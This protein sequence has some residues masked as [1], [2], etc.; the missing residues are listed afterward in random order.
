MPKPSIDREENNLLS[1]MKI[2]FLSYFL[3][4]ILFMGCEKEISDSQKDYFIKMYGSYLRDRAVCILPSTSG[5]FLVCGTS[6]T[7]NNGSDI[8]LFTIDESGNRISDFNYV[9]LEGNDRAYSMKRTGNGFVIS[10]FVTNAQGNLDAAIF[11]VNNNGEIINDL[12][13]FG[14][15]GNDYAYDVE[16]RHEEG[17]IFVGSTQQAGLDLLYIVTVDDNVEGP[18]VSRNLSGIQARLNRVLKTSDGEYIA[19]GTNITD[20]ANSYSRMMLTRINKD[21][22]FY[23]VRYFGNE[24]ENLILNDMVQQNDS[25]IFLMGTLK[26]TQTEVGRVILKKIVDFRERESYTFSADGSLDAKALSLKEDGSLIMVADQTIADDKNVMLFLLNSEGQEIADRKRYGGTGDQT[27]SDV[28][29]QNGSIL[30]LGANSY[31]GNSMISL[32]KTDENGNT[33]N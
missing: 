19:G 29:Y 25:V 4:I 8:V 27:A 11:T 10:A 30:I 16:E 9:G 17:Y 33:W 13:L 15:T 26:D 14:G 7:E 2:K 28:I 21:G 12:S 23:I 20:P 32:I 5:N 3:L 1:L 6:D 18:D 24:N 31:R 22:N